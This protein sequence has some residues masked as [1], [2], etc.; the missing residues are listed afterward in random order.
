MTQ[1]EEGEEVGDSGTIASF[2]ETEEE[3]RGHHP[4]EAECAGLAGGDDAPADNAKGGPHVRGEDL[5]HEGEPFE[6]DVGDVEDCEEPLVVR[7]G[8]VE[9]FCHSC[10]LGVSGG[11]MS[12]G[13]ERG[14]RGERTAST[15]VASGA[16]LLYAKENKKG[17]RTRYSNDLNR[18]VDLFPIHIS[19]N[20][21]LPFPFS[22]PGGHTKPHNQRN[23][24]LIQF[25][26]N[27]PLHLRSHVKSISR[28]WALVS[29]L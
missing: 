15:A 13:C 22:L 28:R 29:A 20:S 2:E 26:H 5:P 8:E 12:A 9:V 1:V 27:P 21:P 3:T 11:R 6:E 4:G 7:G 14:E 25:P 18:P 24:P 23:K 16:S 10:D 17:E 19:I